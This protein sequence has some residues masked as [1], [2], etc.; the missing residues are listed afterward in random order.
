MRK[1]QFHV[2]MLIIRLRV[3]SHM[4]T[5]IEYFCNEIYVLLKQNVYFRN[6]QIIVAVHNMLK[7]P[8]GEGEH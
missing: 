1:W 2:D 6:T 7:A 8:L 4:F 5:E 3:S